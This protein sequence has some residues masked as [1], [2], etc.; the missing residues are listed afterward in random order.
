MI[1]IPVHRK[2]DTSAMTSKKLSRYFLHF[3]DISQTS[4]KEAARE[5]RPV[6]YQ[7]LLWPRVAALEKNGR[8]ANNQ[9]E[10]QQ[11]S[12][13]SHIGCNSRLGQQLCYSFASKTSATEDDNLHDLS[14]PINKLELPS[15]Q[16]TVASC[17]EALLKVPQPVPESRLSIG[18]R[19]RLSNPV[20]HCQE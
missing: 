9:I 19:V 11:S 15:W 7:V 18:G 4:L 17:P 8:G 20:E 3:V 5:P 16:P 6:W 14:Y 1:V 13:K 10:S 12:T 2:E